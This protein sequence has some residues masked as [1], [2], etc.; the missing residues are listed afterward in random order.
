MVIQLSD[1]AAYGESGGVSGQSRAIELGA[2]TS[3]VTVM[4]PLRDIINGEKQVWGKRCPYVSLPF[5]PLYLPPSQ[6]SLLIPVLVPSSPSSS[7]ACPSSTQEPTMGGLSSISPRISLF[8]LSPSHRW[9]LAIG[10]PLWLWLARSAAPLA[11]LPSSS[12]T[13]ITEGRGWGRQ[14]PSRSPALLPSFYISPVFSPAL[15][16]CSPDALLLYTFLN[17]LRPCMAHTWAEMP[18]H[19][20]LHLYTQSDVYTST[21]VTRGGSPR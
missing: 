7:P 1:P 4:G 2:A 11:S 14:C 12:F 15:W 3:P 20:H 8:S 10:Y 9:L 6:L 19:G 13:C 18:I 5:C 16:S 21:W 17:W